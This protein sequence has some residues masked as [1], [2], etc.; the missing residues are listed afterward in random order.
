MNRRSGAR[1]PRTVLAAVL[2]TILGLAHVPAHAVVV[3]FEDVGAPLSPQSA[4]FDSG[5]F[6]SGGASF[7]NLFQDFGGGFTSWAGFAISNV[8]D[9]TTPGFVNQYAAFAGEGAGS[10]ATYAVAFQDSFVPFAPT[11]TF[12][13]DVG[14]ESLRVTNTTYAG[15]S[16]RDGDGF[17]KKFG[18]AG[19]TDPDFFRLTV[20]GFDSH[21]AETAS[22]EFYL[23]DYRFPD[24]GA[25]YVVDDWATL[26]LEL[27]GVVRSLVFELDSSDV[28]AFGMNTPAYFAIDDLVV[29][30]EPGTLVLVA[31]GLASLGV[32]RRA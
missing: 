1:R 11:I 20:R 21:G 31:A 6:T 3:D 2:V 10:S 8:V 12:A 28:G 26:D 25:D 32:R 7:N 23:A 29:V 22:V 4:D 27:L 24:S 30:P 9:T 15:L 17:A 5:G 16:V 19:G 13:T 14:V 18:G